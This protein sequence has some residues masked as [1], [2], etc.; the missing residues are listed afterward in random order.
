MDRLLLLGL[1]LTFCIAAVRPSPP[2]AWRAS[3]DPHVSFSEPFFYPAEVRLLD[4]LDV[5]TPSLVIDIGQ[6]RFRLYDAYRRVVLQGPCATGKDSTLAAPDGRIWTFRTPRGVRRVHNKS[7][8]PVWHR[9]DWY[10]VEEGL[11]VPPSTDPERLATGMLGEYALDVGQGYL[12]HGSPYQRG[13][14]ERITHGCV[15]LG[16]ED[17]RIVYRTLTVGDPV[18]LH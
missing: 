14:G 16:D 4:S 13:I 6:C 11:P 5:R 9:P 7:A 15:R 17:L 8:D 3:R 2:A 12:V 18:I 1:L 10:Y